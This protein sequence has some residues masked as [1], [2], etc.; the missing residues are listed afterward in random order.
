MN[1]RNTAVRRVKSGALKASIYV[2]AA[3]VCVLAAAIAIVV[4]VKGL[5]HITLQFLTEKPSLL[6]GKIGI[7]PNILNTLYIIFFTMIIVIPLGIGAAVYLNEYAKN[8]K[9]T[10]LIGLAAETLSGIPSIIYGLVGMLIF[11]QFCGFG[12]SLIAG[13]MTLVVMTLPTIMRTTEES[14]KAVPQSYREGALA[15]GSG[16]W[17]MLRTV[18]LP[19][20]VDGI[21]TGVILAHGRYGKRDLR[22]C[23]GCFERQRRLNAHSFALYVCKGARRIRYSFRCRCN[24]SYTHTAAQFRSKVCAEALR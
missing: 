8:K 17:R 22:L 12:T 7:L 23:T 6:T 3:I 24:T 19:S 10:G 13:A 5:P 21:I 11:V 2:S 15:L 16:K 1:D 4:L 9:L 20:A 18:V 14:L